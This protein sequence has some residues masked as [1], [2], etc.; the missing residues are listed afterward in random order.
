MTIASDVTRQAGQTYCYD[1]KKSSAIKTSQFNPKAAEKNDKKMETGILEVENLFMNSPEDDQGFLKTLGEMNAKMENLKEILILCSKPKQAD[2]H[3][4]KT[5]ILTV[6]AGIAGDKNP[7]EARKIAMEAGEHADTALKLDPDN[8][9]AN[10]FILDT[11]IN[12]GDKLSAEIFGIKCYKFNPKNIKAHLN[13]LK[14]FGCPDPNPAKI[15]I[16]LMERSNYITDL[17][18]FVEKNPEVNA[19]KLVFQLCCEG[20]KYAD[21]ETKKKAYHKKSLDY[22]KKLVQLDPASRKEA[23]EELKN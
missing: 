7:A 10:Y 13:F 17:E 3:A 22:F 14:M 4:L 23:E 5:I 2:W 11:A 15:K 20:A 6:E 18:K 1:G 16:E 12:M 19:L 21:T 9:R 8:F